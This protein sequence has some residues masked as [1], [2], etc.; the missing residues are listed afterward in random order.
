MTEFADVILA[1][2]EVIAE[3]HIEHLGGAV[4]VGGINLDKAAR[5]RIHRCE[6]HHFRLVLAKTFRA[7]EGILLALDLFED[8]SLFALVVGEVGLFLAALFT[9]GYLEQGRF[10][11]VY[12]ALVYERRGKAVYH[13]QYESAYLESVAPC[14][15]WSAPRRRSRE[16]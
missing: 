8:I 16:P 12:I 10:R 4:G 13:R 6:G 5:L 11:D 9:D 1:S 14:W 7:L 2:L 15:T 3:E